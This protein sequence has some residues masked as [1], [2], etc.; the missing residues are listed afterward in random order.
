MYD[1]NQ[2]VVFNRQHVLYYFLNFEMLQ[3]SEINVQPSMITVSPV[4]KV[5]FFKNLLPRDL[6]Q[7]ILICDINLF[8]L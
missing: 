2:K 5:H 7:E 3:L 4:V 1:E 8:F 6:I